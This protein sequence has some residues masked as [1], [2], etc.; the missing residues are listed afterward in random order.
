M[1]LGVTAAATG[2][3]G[4]DLMEDGFAQSVSVPG[5][6]NLKT[7]KNNCFASTRDVLVA[8]RMSV[9]IVAAAEKEASSS[10]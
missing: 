6:K 4:A 10:F 2:N 3:T 8:T 7:Y 5:E 1:T 9:N